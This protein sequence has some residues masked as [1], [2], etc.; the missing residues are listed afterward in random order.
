MRVRGEMI[1]CVWADSGDRPERSTMG[2]HHQTE[3]L[4][5]TR[6][7]NKIYSID[8]ILGHVKQENN[9]EV[10]SKSSHILGLVNQ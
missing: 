7:N 2:D 4:Q 1:S 8:Q 3:Q 5:S 10:K 9:T 6:I